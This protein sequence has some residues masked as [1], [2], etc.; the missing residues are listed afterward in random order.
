MTITV[1][2]VD[3]GTVGALIALF[4][5]A[6]GL[7]AGL[8]NINAYHQPGVEAGKKAAGTVISLQK[9]LVEMFCRV[10]GAL[11]AGEAA[12]K[13]GR[14]DE[15]EAVFAILRH[16]AANPEKGIALEAEGTADVW[17]FRKN[18]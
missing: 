4:E 1:N 12:A 13:L 8:V 16:L 3:A 7:Y 11:T 14:P 18:K 5:R 10:N 6:V 2:R 9:A 17:T 15:T